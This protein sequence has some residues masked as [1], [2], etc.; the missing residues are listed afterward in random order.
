MA[1]SSSFRI[2]GKDFF[3]QN[4]GDCYTNHTLLELVVVNKFQFVLKFKLTYSRE[5]AQ[6]QTIQHILVSGQLAPWTIRACSHGSGGPWRGEVPHLPLIKKH[7][8]SHNPWDTG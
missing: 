7:L 1:S 2:Y 4:R 8:S 3:F 5:R 6:D